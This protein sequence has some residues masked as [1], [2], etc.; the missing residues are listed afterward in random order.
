MKQCPFC[1]EM[2][3]DDAKVCRHCKSPLVK[4]CPYCAEEI[5]AVAKKCKFC[6][7]DLEKKPEAKP[8]ADVCTGYIGNERNLI[9][10]ILLSIITCGIYALIWIYGIA[11]DIKSHYI[12]S[13][14]KPGQDIL[15]I[16]LLPII[17]VLLCVTI[18]LIPIGIILILIGYIYMIFIMYK[19]PKE[20]YMM[21]TEE[22][23]RA[24][25][26]SLLC[27]ILHIVGLG[28]ASLCIIQH[29]LNTHWQE[30]GT[31]REKA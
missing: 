8:K 7:S 6:G 21:A 29:E 17:G 28:L 14:I 10:G 5:S 12:K 3:Q 1:A 4:S 27:V 9:V 22:G 26:H 20:I 16:L 2:V 13:K 15:I 18:I 25:D 23:L 31:I 30:H 11:N 24:S 19:Y